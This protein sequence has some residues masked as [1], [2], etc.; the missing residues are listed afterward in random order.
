[1]VMMKVLSIK[2]PFAS[3]ISNGIKRIETRSFKTKYRGEIYIH[4]SANY[5]L[6]KLNGR[7]ELLSMI[8]DLD[9]F[10]GYILCKA[11]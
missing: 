1:M 9:L 3:L 4:A 7:D 8:K 2:E 10:P 6:K 11:N 5:S